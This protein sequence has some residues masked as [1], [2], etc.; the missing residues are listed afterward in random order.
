MNKMIFILVSILVIFLLAIIGGL[1]LWDRGEFKEEIINEEV[2]L[3]AIF[4]A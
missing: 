1:F 2:A 3:V 4:H